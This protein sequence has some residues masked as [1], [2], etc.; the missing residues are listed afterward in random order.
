[1]VI[2]HSYVSL[3]EGILKKNAGVSQT[4]SSCYLRISNLFKHNDFIK[5]LSYH[6]FFNLQLGGP[7]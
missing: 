3:P 5:L 7:I 1:M 4:E 2:F 6:R